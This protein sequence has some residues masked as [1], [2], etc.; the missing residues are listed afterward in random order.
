MERLAQVLLDVVVQRPERGDVDDVDAV[1]QPA[2]G[3]EAVQ[4]VERP[5]EGGQRLAGAGGSHDQRVA[6]GSDGVP[7]LALRARGLGKCCIEPA[8]DERQERGHRFIVRAGDSLTSRRRPARLTAPT[9]LTAEGDIRRT[10][11]LTLTGIRTNGLLFLVFPEQWTPGSPW[12]DVRGRRAAS[13]AIDRQAINEAESLG[14]SGPTG[15]FVPRHHEFALAIPPDP[16]DPK[17]AKALLAEAGYPNGFEAGDFTPYPPYNGM[18]EAIANYLAAVGIKVRVRI[19][20]RA[21]FLSSWRDKKLK[22][23][24]VCATGAAGNA[25]TRIEPYATSKGVNAYGTFPEI[26]SLFQRQLQE[27]DRK[28]REE[29]LHQVQ[30]M[31]AERVMFAPIWEN[32]F[33]PAYGPRV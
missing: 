10:P 30:R 32:G 4:V 15:G 5:Q 27:M 12:A 26:E 28:K 2:L 8:A 31:L 29:I 1:F 16:Y 19:M 9:S 13:L 21:A 22:N 6:A 14:F 3:G 20:E 23:V 17:R 11:G 33:I 7:A 18:G 24:F 25:S